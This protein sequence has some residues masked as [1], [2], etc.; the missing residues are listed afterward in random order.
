MKK[1]GSLKHGE[2]KATNKITKSEE[3]LMVINTRFAINVTDRDYLR[4]SYLYRHGKFKATLK[5][6][7]DFIEQC[8]VLAA[9]PLF[10]L[11]HLFVDHETL[12]YETGHNPTIRALKKL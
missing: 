1:S 11:G 2:E 12:V 3:G 9:T 6:N 7:K 5:T 4:I 8:K 10:K